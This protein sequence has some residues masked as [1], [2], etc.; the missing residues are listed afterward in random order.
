[1]NDFDLGINLGLQGG[2]ECIRAQRFHDGQS[3][4]QKAGE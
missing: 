4:N 1:L 2:I 3:E